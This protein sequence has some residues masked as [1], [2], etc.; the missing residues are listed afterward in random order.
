MNAPRSGVASVR[1][2]K[3][4][5]GMLRLAL[6]S[7]FAACAAVPASHP[8]VVDQA[9][10]PLHVE[11]NRPFI[12]ISFKK[13][14][15]STHTGRFL[16]DSGGGGFLITE[17]LARNLG[18]ATGPTETEEGQQIAKVTSPVSAFVS[19]LPLALDPQR[20]IVLVGTTNL[21]PPVAPGH[22][23]SSPCP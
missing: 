3:H 12:D 21:L 4:A 2:L 14:D 18:L 22:A 17:P 15:G 1:D 19:E 5:A 9:T 6:I 7:V 8:H 16:I 13:P 10:V 11:G 23:D 20:T